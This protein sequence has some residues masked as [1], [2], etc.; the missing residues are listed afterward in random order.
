MGCDDHCTAI[1]VIK[2]AELKNSKL[3]KKCF[4]PTYLHEMELC[5]NFDPLTM[6][7][8][9]LLQECV[10]NRKTGT[11]NMEVEPYFFKLL[12]CSTFI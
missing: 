6:S 1:N 2:F 8:F 10:H 7:S 4:L 11:D 9:L 12:F 3:V 5:F